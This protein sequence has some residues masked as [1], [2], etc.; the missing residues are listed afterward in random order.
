MVLN[1]EIHPLNILKNNPAQKLKIPKFDNDRKVKTIS[2][3][4][5]NAIVNVVKLSLVKQK[6]ALLIGF[7]TGMRETEIMS[8]T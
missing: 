3:D 1:Y 4:E 8:F 6:M 2:V 5:F 7:H